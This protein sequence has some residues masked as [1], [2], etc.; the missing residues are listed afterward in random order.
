[1]LRVILVRHGETDWNKLHRVQGSNSDAPLNESGKEQAD[2]LALRLKQEDIQA[3]YSS[4][5]KR[6]LGTAQV[7]A[8][9]HQLDVQVESDLREMNV[10]ELEGISISLVSKRLDEL[11]AMRN[12][13]D[14]TPVE[15]GESMWSKVQHIGG[16]S[17]GEVQQRSWG[18]VRRIAD[19]H[20]DGAVVIVSHYFVIITVICA[21]LNLAVSRIGRLGFSVG[22]ISTIVFDGQATRLTLFNDTCHLMT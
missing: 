20:S 21:V 4:P 5:L 18:V 8:H 9:H 15:P 1:L 17:P 3:I 12:Q 7:I 16:E 14:V 11:L 22:S 10:G 13:Q 19:Q 6:A 2:R